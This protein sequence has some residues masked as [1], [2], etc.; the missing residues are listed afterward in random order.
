MDISAAVENR[1]THR[2]WPHRRPRHNLPSMQD[3]FPHDFA[4]PAMTVDFIEPIF[5]TLF[6]FVLIDDDGIAHGVLSS[7]EELVGK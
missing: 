6:A 1:R 2:L 7:G 3:H 5:E 4:N